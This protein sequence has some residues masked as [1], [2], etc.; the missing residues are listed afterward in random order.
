MP[1]AIIVEAVF[2]PVFQKVRENARR[3]SCQS[4]IKQI[5]LR[6]MQYQHDSDEKNVPYPLI[7]V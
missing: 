4:N 5:T 7:R 3:A 1:S 2:F 6:V